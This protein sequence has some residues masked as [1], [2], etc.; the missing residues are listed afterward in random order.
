MMPV[1]I[2]VWVWIRIGPAEKHAQPRWEAISCGA[3]A[4]SEGDIF[5]YSCSA[6]LISLEVDSISKEIN[7]AEHEYMNKSPSLIA[8]APLLEAILRP[9]FRLKNFIFPGYITPIYIK[10]MITLKITLISKE[11]NLFSA[12]YMPKRFDH[13]TQL[14]EHWASIPKVVGRIPAEVRHIFQLVRCGYKLSV[15][16]N[17]INFT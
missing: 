13:I 14:V 10:I 15:T 6:Q 1:G 5:I 3:S 12:Y 9:S 11:L 16:P 7:C 8:L 4:I 2:T 17:N